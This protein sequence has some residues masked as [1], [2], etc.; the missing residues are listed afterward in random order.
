MLK[1][2]AM[3][4]QKQANIDSKTEAIQIVAR[5]KYEPISVLEGQLEKANAL[6]NPDPGQISDLNKKLEAAWVEFNGYQQ[7]VG[8]NGAMMG[9]MEASSFA[10]EDI[11][12]TVFPDKSFQHMNK[13]D[14]DRLFAG[15]AIMDQAKQ[16]KLEAAAETAGVTEKAKMKGRL[17]AYKEEGY[18]A[19]GQGTQKPSINYFDQAEATFSSGAIESSLLSHGMKEADVGVGASILNRTGARLQGLNPADMEITVGTQKASTNMDELYALWDKSDKKK[20]EATIE[21][22]QTELDM[23]LDRI[24]ELDMSPAMNQYYT[25]IMDGL[26]EALGTGD[27]RIISSYIDLTKG[28]FPKQRPQLRTSAGGN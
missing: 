4:M 13:E 3:Q 22:M 1:Q 25:T 17:Q 24:D 20:S 2:Q 12:N 7:A 27:Q 10:D 19:P 11:R 6:P 16:A 28:L 9:M 21:K 23:G 14:R 5:Q 26:N 15:W 18:R 8:A